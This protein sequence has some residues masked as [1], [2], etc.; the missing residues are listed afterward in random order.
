MQNQRYLLMWQWS[1]HQILAT[2]VFLSDM[3]KRETNI[4]GI[5]YYK[6]KMKAILLETKTQIQP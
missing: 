5:L 3:S 6:S 1:S 4:N 2:P